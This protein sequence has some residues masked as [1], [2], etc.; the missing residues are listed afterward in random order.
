MELPPVHPLRLDGLPFTGLAG[1]V[2]VLLRRRR[3]GLA[4]LLIVPLFPLRDAVWNALLQ[5]VP[6]WLL[7]SLPS[8]FFSYCCRSFC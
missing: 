8:S 5:L 6:V 3:L 2:A 1:L 4:L 7:C